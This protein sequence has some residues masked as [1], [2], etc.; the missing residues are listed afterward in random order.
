M[1]EPKNPHVYDFGILGRV[2]E[3]QNQYYLSLET[4]RYLQH[5]KKK[6]IIFK[7]IY[8][9]KSQLFGNPDVR[10]FPKRRAP[11]TPADPSNEILK[12]LDIG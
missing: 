7:N 3:P 11:K 10:P 1:G 2:P 8:I 6:R 4:P 12:I 5:S 9:I